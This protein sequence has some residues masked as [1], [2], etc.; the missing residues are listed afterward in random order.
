MKLIVELHREWIEAQIKLTK[1]TDGIMIYHGT[2][3][4]G[5]DCV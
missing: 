1:I 2:V 5:V 3:E 4:D